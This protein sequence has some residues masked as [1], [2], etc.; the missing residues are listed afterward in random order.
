[1][2]PDVGLRF[3]LFM[4]TSSQSFT[5]SCSGCNGKVTSLLASDDSGRL[6]DLLQ[7]G[8][9]GVV[10]SDGSPSL[11][12]SEREDSWLIMVL[13]GSLEKTQSL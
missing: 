12:E 7:A 1:M 11:F 9:K 5:A 6:C 2:H 10:A 8:G 13:A 3:R 4:E